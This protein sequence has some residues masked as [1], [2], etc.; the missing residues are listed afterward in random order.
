MHGTRVSDLQKR[1]KYVLALTSKVLMKLYQNVIQNR[2]G[3]SHKNK[4]GE[5]TKVA[6][7]NMGKMAELR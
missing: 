1:Y 3:V 2:F 6:P 4:M 7:P 5:G